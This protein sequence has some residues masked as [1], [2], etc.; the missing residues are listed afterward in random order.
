MRGSSRRPAREAILRA[1]YEIEVGHTPTDAAIEDTLEH[2]ELEPELAEFARAAIK[3]VLAHL[4]ALD[5]A[6]A[7]SLR[8][9]DLSRVATVDRNILRLAAYELFHCPPI[10]PA[11]TINEAV[12]LAKKYST[13][14]SGRFVN[15]VLGN[16]LERT[17]KHEWDPASAPPDERV[18]AAAPEPEPEVETVTEDSEEAQELA[19][20][21]LWTVRKEETPQ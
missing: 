20:A 8:D 3:G 19:R 1:L 21:G 12:D 10:P 7:Q 13:A 11:V 15:G 14:E 17:P 18:G 2:A 6:L 9:W 16:L 4:N 5:G